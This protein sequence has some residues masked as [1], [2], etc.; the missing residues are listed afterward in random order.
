MT[1]HRRS[2]ASRRRNTCC[3]FPH[4]TFT[5][6]AG[7]DLS[8]LAAMDVAATS[9]DVLGIVQR[10]I[11]AERKRLEKEPLSLRSLSDRGFW[12]GLQLRL[13][14]GGEPA[15]RDALWAI[16]S[17][18]AEEIV[19][20][21]YNLGPQ[22]GFQG[23]PAFRTFTVPGTTTFS[24][25]TG[26]VGQA[27]DITLDAMTATRIWQPMANRAVLVPYTNGEVAVFDTQT[28]GFLGSVSTPGTQIFGTLDQ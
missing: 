5:S 3:C 27:Q 18:Y 6:S 12:F 22:P 13:R 24:V 4:L 8:D 2:S 21:N 15:A 1:S 9:D 16:V 20:L 10:S 19:L 23:T 26:A 28:L 25:P 7:H 17:N 11:D 14:L